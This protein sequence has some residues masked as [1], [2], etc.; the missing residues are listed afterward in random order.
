MEKIWAGRAEGNLN[1]AAEDLNSSIRIDGR[2]YEEDITA[3][4]AHAIML[5]ACGIVTKEEA[6]ELVKGLQS[7]LFDIRSGRLDISMDAEDIHTFVESVLT[8]RI[9]DTGKKLHTARSRNDQVAT[10]VRL[11]LKKRTDNLIKLLLELMKALTKKA[12][13]HKETV[14]PGFTHLQIAQPVTFSQHL[15]AYVFMFSR[16]VQRLFD[17]KKRLNVMPLGSCALAGTTYPIDRFMTCNLLNFS[18]PCENSMDGVSDR[19]FCLELA[20]CLSII[21]THLSRLS[22][23]LVLFSSWQFGFIT[24]SDSFTT[25]S[26]IM[27]QKKNPDMAELIRGK[28][29]SVFGNLTAL[30]TMLKALPLCYNKDMQEDKKAIFDSFDT[31]ESCLEVAVP[32]IKEM[33]VNADA[34]RLHAEKGYINATD[35]ADYL[36]KKGMPF[37][38]AYK[39]TAKIVAD[40]SKEKI[41]LNELC[42]D[43]YKEYSALFDEDLYEAI[44]VKNCALLR[45]SYGAAGAVDTQFEIALDLITKAEEALK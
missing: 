26:S 2:M 17:A 15:M 4:I 39:L 22:E 9:G 43:K 11:Y 14:M 34:M 7:I 35:L 8:E 45:K 30:L 41:S 6:A 37:R 32:M 40:L 3:S 29:G 25:G 44:D 23:E 31:A 10:D 1:K 27:P 19:D 20:S 24:L 16:D 18:Y 28:C 13:E 38:D 42:L 33:T 12:K 36:A 5:G 21:M